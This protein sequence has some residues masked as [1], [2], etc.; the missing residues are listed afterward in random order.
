MIVTLRTVLLTITST[1]KVEFRDK[2]KTRPYR[3]VSE[4][5]RFLISVPT[6]TLSDTPDGPTWT[7]PPKLVFLLR[8]PIS[9]ANK[10]GGGRASPIF[11]PFGPVAA[12]TKSV[13][14][15][16]RDHKRAFTV[17]L[18]VTARY[19]TVLPLGYSVRLF[20]VTRTPPGE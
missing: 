5:T 13:F 7:S 14:T 11:A 15:F 19:K 1:I 9:G 6:N 18:P 17:R 3:L 16:S 2:K 8:S 10:G 12:R 20:T 4:P